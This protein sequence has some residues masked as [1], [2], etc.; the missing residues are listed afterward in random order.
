M[1][2][3]KAPFDLID[4]RPTF[5]GLLVYKVDVNRKSNEGAITLITTNNPTREVNSNLVGTFGVGEYVE[6]DGLRITNLG[7]SKNGYYVEI[8]KS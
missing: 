1:K 6:T 3:E 4:A 7:N 8:K 5:E 2:L